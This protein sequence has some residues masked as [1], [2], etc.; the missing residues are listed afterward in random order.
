MGKE[1]KQQTV[2]EATNGI[3]AAAWNACITPRLE[4]LR[5]WFRHPE[6]AEGIGAYLTH[7]Q[8]EQLKLLVKGNTNPMDDKFV[9]GRISMLMEILEMPG[10]I[11][12][13]INIKEQIKK[14]P[15][16]EGEAGY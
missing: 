16:P 15:H 8:K 10:V 13:H 6:W 12:N 7:Q 3:K 1:P 11:E 5:A 2:E 9:M 4:A 14:R